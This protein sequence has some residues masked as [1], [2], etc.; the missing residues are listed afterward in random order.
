MKWPLD[1]FASIRGN[2]SSCLFTLQAVMVPQ[3]RSSYTVMLRDGI[4]EVQYNDVLRVTG[5]FLTK[6]NVWVLCWSNDN[7]FSNLTATAVRFI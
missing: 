3:V 5:L 2:Q 4:P 6:T 1:L 7:Q